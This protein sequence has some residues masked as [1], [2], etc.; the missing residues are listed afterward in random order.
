ME[1]ELILLQK[2][3][4]EHIES[5]EE[6]FKEGDERMNML[7]EC[8][9]KNSSAIAELT[10]SI[11]T[12]TKETFGVVQLHKDL[13]NVVRLGVTVQRVGVWV[14]TWPLIGVCI[15][16]IYKWITANFNLG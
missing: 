12:L 7:I 16:A 3:L 13:R 9:N 1:K 6:R 15:L 8:A 5:C 11:N 14:V 10:T 4:D 2:N